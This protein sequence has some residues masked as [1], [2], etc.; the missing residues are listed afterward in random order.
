MNTDSFISLLQF[1]DGLFPAGAYAHS[2]GLEYYVQ[3][4]E[5]RDASG[6]RDFIQANLEGSLA[7][8]DAVAML[9]A[10]QA[11][12]END[13]K[14]VLSL[15][16]MIDAM[17]PI[18]ELR[19]ASRQMGRQ[20]IRVAASLLDNTLLRDYFQKVDAGKSPGHHPAAFGVVGGLLGWSRGDAA[21]AY[22]YAASAAITGASLRLLPLGQMAGQR[23]LW[24]LTPLI[25]R[26][27]SHAQ[28]KTAAQDVSAMWSFVPGLEIASMQHAKLDARLFRS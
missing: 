6:V 12:Q 26:L 11:A 25:A 14:A 18:A 23:I 1:S 8:A 15:D 21:Q 20:T 10:F 24:E 19:N 7:T 16:Q 2:F 4:G 27:A 9:C 5:V 13:L 3:S 22:L 28:E 17:K